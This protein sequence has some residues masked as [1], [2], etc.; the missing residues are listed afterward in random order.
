MQIEVRELTEETVGDAQSVILSRFST[1]ALGVLHKVMSNPLRDEHRGRGD[2]LY[3]DGKPVAFRAAMRR[4]MFLGKRQI[5]GRVRGLTCRLKDSPKNSISLLVEAQKK[6]R[7]GCSIAISNTQ[8]VPT[9]RRAV[10]NGALLGPES[11]ARYLWRAVRPWACLIYFLRRRVFRLEPRKQVD[12]STMGTIGYRRAC[13]K[14]VFKRL[15]ITD[16][17]FFDRLM[18][19]Y[20]KTNSGLVSS[21]TGEEISWIYG[22]RLK[23]GEVVIIGMEQAGSPLGYILLQSDK[24]ARR[25]LIGDMFVLDNRKEFIDDLL[26]EGC[27]FLRRHTP[28]MLLESIGFPMM[29]QPVIRKWLPFRRSCPAN[30][31]SFNF[32]SETDSKRNNSLV[33]SDKSW[34]FGP[35]DGDM[36]LD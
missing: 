17:S 11:C 10:Q 20:L 18:D 16:L 25:W 27:L 23:S 3:V 14:F 2:I 15:T 30:Y 24:K 22:E 28:A 9:E 36:C 32:L 12:F 21:R 26:A 34:F 4:K 6:N 13:R 7:R 1:N 19:S 29:V 31:D 5:L 35:Y 8:C 33:L